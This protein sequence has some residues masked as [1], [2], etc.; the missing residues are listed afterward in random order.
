MKKI[1]LIILNFII[2]RFDDYNL[3]FK[4]NKGI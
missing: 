3:D 2:N 1:I 4:I